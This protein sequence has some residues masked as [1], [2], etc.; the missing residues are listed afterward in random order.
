MNFY[1]LTR[2]QKI[3]LCTDATMNYIKNG[4]GGLE[5]TESYLLNGFIGYKNYSDVELNT[6]LENAFECGDLNESDFKNILT[7][8]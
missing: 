7:L 8:S 1:N 6:E 4:D 5:L 3:Q 2:E